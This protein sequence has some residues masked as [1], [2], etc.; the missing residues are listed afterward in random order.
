[1]ILFWECI[2]RNIINYEQQRY[3]QLRDNSILITNMHLAICTTNSHPHSPQMLYRSRLQIKLGTSLFQPMKVQVFNDSLLF[4]YIETKTL[5]HRLKVLASL[6]NL[7]THQAPFL[8]VN[9]K[10]QLQ[11]RDMT[12]FIAFQKFSTVCRTTLGTLMTPYQQDRF[13][14]NSSVPEN[15]LRN[16]QQYQI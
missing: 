4:S 11:D 3:H 5:Y 7:E 6:T 13:Y 14:Y 12:D 16:Q 1:M 10:I 9:K 8:Q 2:N 15:T